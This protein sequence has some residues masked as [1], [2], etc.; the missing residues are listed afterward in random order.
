MEQTVKVI[1]ASGSPRRRELFGQI[2]I[3]FTVI[4]SDAEEMITKTVPEEVVM[5][6]A[7]QKAAAVKEQLSEADF[8]CKETLIVGADTIVVSEGKILGKPRDEK[9]AR[10]ILMSLSGKEHSVFT[11][12]RGIYVDQNGK[13]DE[14]KSFC[15]AE[16]TVVIMYPFLKEEAEAYIRTKEPMDKAGAYGIQGKGA[17]LVKEIRGDYN[18]VV[19]FPLAAFFRLGCQKNF[20]RL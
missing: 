9:D 10:K 15:F 7:M 13:I 8:S 16:E 2:G 3:E 19:G 4:K 20:F 11:G 1:L 14:E 6:L 18:N 17:V 5:E 12:V